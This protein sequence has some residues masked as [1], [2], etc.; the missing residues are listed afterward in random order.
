VEILTEASSDRLRSLV[1]GDEFFWLD[2]LRPSEEVVM[3]LVDAIGLDPRAAAR[4]LRFGATPELRRYESHAGL[5]FFGAEPRGQGPAGLVEVHL[6]VRG[7][8]VVTVRSEACGALDRLRVDLREGPAPAEESVV[9]RIL[10]GLAE[11]FNDLMDPI[12]EAIAR[13]ETTA[14]E[15]DESGAP[16][17]PLRTEILER[18][19]R[20]WQARRLVR[21]QRDYVDRAVSELEDLPGLQAAERHEFR[22]VS[23]E[24][25]R[26]SD[27]IDDALDR[28]AASLDLL[29]STL[30]NRLNAIM[31]RL[32]VVATIFLPLTFVTGFFG[33]NFDWMVRRI[34]TFAAFA[35]LGMGLSLGSGIAVALWVRSRLERRSSGV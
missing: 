3:G 12:D 34:D 22:D 25:I 23:G 10:E 6:F 19:G 13:L 7:D 1:S 27:R 24:M 8:W 28:L 26:V 29:N 5:V 15:A 30:S 9:A 14:A 21:R 35:I 2:L 4:A 16:I 17:P 11:S 33:M 32:T 31:E 18:R 20:L